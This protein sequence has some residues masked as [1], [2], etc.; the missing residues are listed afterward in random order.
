MLILNGETYTV[1]KKTAG[2]KIRWSCSKV[3]SGCKGAVITD[4][5]SGNAR[6]R[7]AHNHESR[8]VKTEVTK[9]QTKIQTKRGWDRVGWDTIKVRSSR[10]KVFPL[11]KNWLDEI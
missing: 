9:F 3:K 5:P 7:T 1:K 8:A 11:Y 6:N 10:S 4:D 2:V